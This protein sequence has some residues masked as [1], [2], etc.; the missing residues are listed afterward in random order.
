VPVSLQD[1][2]QEYYALRGW[3][4]EGI[5]AQEKLRELQLM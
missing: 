5:P 3:D 1:Q 4:R 2:L